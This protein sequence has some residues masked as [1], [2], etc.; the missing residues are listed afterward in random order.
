MT[1]GIYESLITQSLANKLKE[2]LKKEFS[3]LM[4]ITWKLEE[5]NTYGQLLLKWLLVDI[6]VTFKPL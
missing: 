3:K 2:L 6:K 4:S 1:F 5:P